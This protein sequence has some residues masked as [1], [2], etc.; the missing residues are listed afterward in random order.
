MP[1]VAHRRL[2]GC[3]HR[4]HHQR[5][6]VCGEHQNNHFPQHAHFLSEATLQETVPAA[7]I[8]PRVRA[9]DAAGSL[10]PTVFGQ[11]RRWPRTCLRS[12][13]MKAPRVR[14]NKKYAGC[15]RFSPRARNAWSGPIADSGGSPGARILGRRDG[16]MDPSASADEKAVGKRR[17]LSGPSVFRDV[18]VDQKK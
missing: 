13:G 4:N 17:L 9:L 12:P 10:W 6:R 3:D 16:L 14:R 1:A 18:R 8:F 5:G 7:R 15:T 11:C 2:G